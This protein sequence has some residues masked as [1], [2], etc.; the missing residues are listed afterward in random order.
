MS[1]FTPPLLG[2]SSCSYCTS[3]RLLESRSY[4]SCCFNVCMC[5]SGTYTL[6]VVRHLT[7]FRFIFWQLSSHFYKQ[8]VLYTATATTYNFSTHSYCYC[9]C[10]CLMFYR[11]PLHCSPFHAL[12]FCFFFV[13]WLNSFNFIHKSE[14]GIWYWG[15]YKRVCHIW[16]DARRGKRPKNCCKHIGLY[17]INQIP[18]YFRLVLLLVLQLLLILL[19]SLL[20]MLPLQVP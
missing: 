7:L 9:C 8:H 15:V 4:C 19:V 18:I 5:V 1:Y 13:F 12:Y 10:C 17:F 2:M 14:Y 20:L 6:T 11:P 3:L 16:R